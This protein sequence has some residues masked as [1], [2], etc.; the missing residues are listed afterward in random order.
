M[1]VLKNNYSVFK[2][3]L[4]A[5]QKN[6]VKPYPRKIICEKCQSEL[7]YD[8]SDLR[9]GVYGAMFIDCPCCGHDNMLNDNENSI[10]LTKDNVEF[11]VHF[12]H[13]S[14]DN[15]AEDCCNNEE[16]AKCI[17]KAIDFFRKNKDEYIWFTQYGNLSVYV[18][19]CGD[20]EDYEVF[21]SNDYYGTYIP[22]EPQDY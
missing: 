21:V 5:L 6:V 16:V 13:T 3:S 14:K 8:E 12:H 18:H 9:M 15:G 2:D 17:R 4:E 11:P 19:R 10:T 22:F 7:Q 20:A 1:K